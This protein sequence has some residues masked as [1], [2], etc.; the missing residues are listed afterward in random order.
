MRFNVFTDYCLRTLIYLG[1]TAENSQ[2]TRA[3]VAQAYGISDNHLMKVVHWLASEH[4][5][6]SMRGRGGGIRLAREPQSIN[7]GELVRKSE[8]DFYLVECFEPGA[9]RCRIESGCQLKAVLYEALEAM[10]QVLDRYT[11]AS[12]LQDRKTLIHLLELP[13]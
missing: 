3:E 13:L 11:L 10:Y 8:G 2:A 4:Y 7:I 9:F 1:S 5:I 12:L 6:E